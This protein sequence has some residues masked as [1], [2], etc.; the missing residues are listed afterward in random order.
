M[1]K[2]SVMEII[3]KRNGVSAENV[4]AQ[5]QK[6]IEEAI[7]TSREKNDVRAMQMWDIITDGTGKC[8]AMELINR[9]AILALLKG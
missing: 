2:G 3:A 7:R 8:T 5:I 6:A 1:E 4:E 9:L